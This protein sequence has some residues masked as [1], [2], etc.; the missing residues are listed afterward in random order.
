M[1]TTRVYPGLNNSSVE[2]FN[3]DNQVKFF[4]DSKMKDFHEIPVSTLL[5]LRDALKYQNNVDTILKDW[6]P[7]SEMKRIEKFV[8]CRY[9]GLDHEADIK[10]LELQKGEYWPCPMRGMCKGDGI[11]CKKLTYNN[12]TLSAKEI[13]LMQLLSTA[14][15]NEALADEID[16]PLGSFHVF[17]KE[18][19]KKLNIQTKQEA[20]IIA[21][22]LNL[23]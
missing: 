16:L 6:H 7:E 2:F 18:L 4:S 1:T 11:V 5:L 22:K 15:T 20:V 10:N 3:L 12:E 21:V 13:K 14:L 8:S 17:K 23:L 19:Y 9:G